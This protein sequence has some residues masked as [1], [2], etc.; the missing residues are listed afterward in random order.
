MKQDATSAIY[1]GDITSAICLYRRCGIADVVSPMSHRRYGLF[2][3]VGS[4]PK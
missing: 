3:I 4:S 2:N 1:I